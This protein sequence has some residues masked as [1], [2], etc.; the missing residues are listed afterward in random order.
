MRQASMTSQYGRGR[1][2]IHSSRSSINASTGSNIG[3]AQLLTVTILYI[4]SARDSIGHRQIETTHEKSLTMAE[5]KYILA[6]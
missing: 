2:P 1:G 5:V 3:A 4:Q 6:R